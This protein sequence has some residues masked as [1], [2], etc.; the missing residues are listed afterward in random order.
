MKDRSGMRIMHLASEYPPIQVFGLG[1]AVRDLAVAQ[2]KLDHDVQVV[3][4]SIGGR[5]KD[6]EVDGVWVHR[7]DFPPP[8]KPPDDTMGVMQFNISALETAIQLIERAEAPDVF[9]VHDWLTVLSGRM[10]K[11]LHPQ[12][13]QCSLITYNYRA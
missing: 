2:A 3:T 8:P 9:H 1:R 4:N 12:A 13:P 5:D 11:W 6:K 10:A 7:I